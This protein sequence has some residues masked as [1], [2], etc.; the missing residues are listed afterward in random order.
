MLKPLSTIQLIRNNVF[1]TDF[2][3]NIMAEVLLKELSNADV[4]W[5][6][7]T[8]TRE[9]VEADRILVQRCKNPGM[10]YLLLEGSLA[11]IVPQ[12]E[13]DLDQEQSSISKA[14]ARSD[15]E[16]MQLSNGEIVG[17]STL[18]DSCLMP[19]VIKT[20]TDSLVLSIDRQKLVKKLEKDL[21]FSNHFYRAIALMLSERL[22]FLLETSSQVRVMSEPSMK[23]VL[24][25]FAELRDSD[26]DW[27]V[28]AGK[29]QSLMAGD[30]LLQ[31][32]K[33]VDALHIV[34]NGL[35]QV[36]APKDH[37]N[38]FTLCFEC[39]NTRANLEQPIATVSR[40]EISG[41]ISFLD[42]RPHPVTARAIEN[43]LVLS[44]PRPI[45]SARLQQD[46]SFASRFYRVLSI[47]LSDSLQT[48]LNQLT[49]SQSMHSAHQPMNK[50]MEY[51]DELNLDSLHQVS[52]G[53]AR[54][55]W[56]LKRLGVM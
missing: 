16:V 32:G 53:A 37:Y 7:H 25:I 48:V 44:I 27:L 21:T 40:G 43:T 14:N 26:V 4:D 23:E 17:E 45:L 50:E 47:Q 52:Q 12:A 19:A 24:F 31:A 22:R 3:G 39:A 9:V 10:L 41:A 42:F 54:F 36:S 49:G 34:L 38:P 15:R 13:T 29:I 46:F 55:N 20:L 2:V 51:D 35:L 18:F 5:L 6:I 8:G 28:A 33:P 1:I 56:M 30:V 11:M